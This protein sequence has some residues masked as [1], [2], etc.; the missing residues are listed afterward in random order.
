MMRCLH[1]PFRGCQVMDIDTPSLLVDLD[2]M[3]RNLHWMQQKAQNAGVSLRPHI[4][5]HR[6]PDIAKKQ[7]IAG[8][9]GITVAKLGEAEVMAAAGITDIFIANEI[10]GDI[11]MDRLLALA[12]KT[13]LAV[14]VDSAEHI[15]MLAETFDGEPHPLNVMI[16]IDTGY[17]RTGVFS[18][19]TAL[20]LAKLIRYR[21][22]VT[23]M[24]IFTHDGQSYNAESLS[25]IRAISQQSQSQMLETAE[26]IRSVGIPVEVVSIGST[27]SLLVS[28]ILA[29]V[30]E[31][32]PGT[33]IFLDADQAG[34]L[35]TYD[36]CALSV[37]ATVI[38]RPAPD[39]VVLDAGTKA[40][41]Y[42]THHGGMTSSH[43]FGVL[44]NR[45][46]VT[47]QSLSDEHA[48]FT[49]PHDMSFEIGDKVEIIPNH[50]CPTCN[51]YSVIYGVRNGEVAEEYEILAR[52]M[53]R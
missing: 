3:E 22:S 49:P 15:K 27:P 45:P 39:R 10:V 8:A 43:G 52:G 24:G 7:L 28:E 6:T 19:E 40:L 2:V 13:N 29:G 21:D 33:Y 47:L 4:K 36:H 17:H 30:T 42:Y 18:K 9:K 11:K 44:K 23:L 35:G 14:G 26:Y 46:S 1:E 12:R 20:E 32:R 31:I 53:S 34:I 38:S 16:D 41:T 25:A 50:A 51:L 37:L 5:T 48:L